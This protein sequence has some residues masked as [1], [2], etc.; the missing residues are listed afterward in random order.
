MSKVICDVCGTT[1]PDTASSCPIC[2]CA[3]RQ[4]S[5]TAAGGEQDQNGSYNYVKGGRF[6]KGNVRKRNSKKVVKEPR[7]N[8]P[9]GDDQGANKG[10]VIVVLVL[11][12]AIVAVLVYIGIRVLGSV[13]APKPNTQNPGQQGGQV[14]KKPCVGLSLE[15]P[16]I[17]FTG[18]DET[19]GLRVVKQPED[20]T[21]TVIFMSANPKIATVDELGNVVSVGVGQT[22][23]YVICGEYTVQCTVVCT[24]GSTEPSEPTVDPL[25]G[26]EL[27]L[28]RDDFTLSKQGEAWNLFK[29]N[30]YGVTA[31]D[32]TWSVD[33]PN[34]ATVDSKGTVRGVN[35]GSTTVW[36]TFRG[37]MVSCIVRVS[38]TATPESNYRVSISD[39]T[40][41]VGGSVSV[42]VI[43]KSDSANVQGIVWTAQTEGV[44]T[45]DGTKITGE[46]VGNVTLSTTYEGETF[47]CIVRVKAATQSNPE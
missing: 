26:F 24:D 14:D 45:I 2:G 25:A 39:V 46:Q 32:I 41:E 3:A 31:E 10:L 20:T 43:R 5:Q 33:N 13:E 37:Q 16:T 18:P 42:N 8:M 19:F 17:N 40:I 11:L 44:V 7:S 27:H 47:T 9:K 22:V 23:I 36:A 1:Y 28:N 21:D 6:S 4:P 15:T 12:L 29:K 30:E 38:F 34:V 35:K